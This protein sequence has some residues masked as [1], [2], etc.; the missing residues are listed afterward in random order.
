M[1]GRAWVFEDN[2]DTDNI[3][4][5]RFGGD[6]TLEEIGSHAF[7]DFR[8]EFGREVRQGD[9]VVAGY[10]YAC[11]SY[12]ETA[13]LCVKVLGVRVIIA[14][15]FSRAFYRNAINNGLWLITIG[16]REFDC[17][18]GD[19]LEVDPKLGSVTNKTRGTHVLG[20]PLSGIAVEIVEADG[21][22]NYFKPR[23]IYP[24]ST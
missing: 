17:A 19:F 24:K 11:G 2:I 9:F 12:R 4:P 18:D 16:D 15:S 3:F 6:A 22:T 5:T 7:I 13:A 14:R 21:A 23:V 10:N 1:A 8:P 20:T